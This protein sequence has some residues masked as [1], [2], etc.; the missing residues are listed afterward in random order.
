MKVSLPN[1]FEPKLYQNTLKKLGHINGPI[2]QTTGQVNDSSS[3]QESGEFVGLDS[4]DVSED[5]PK[6]IRRRRLKA[7]QIALLEHEY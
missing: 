2:R 6:K 3:S 5:V 4:E 7:E 1:H